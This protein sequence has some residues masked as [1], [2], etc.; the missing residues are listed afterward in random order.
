MSGNGLRPAQIF[1]V[2]TATVALL[3]IGCPLR[4]QADSKTEVAAKARAILEKHCSKCHGSTDPEE[5]LNV[6][7]RASLLDAAR[8]KLA[9]ALG[10]PDQSNLIKR[11]E[12]E[13]RPMP[14][15]KEKDPLSKDEIAT[16][17][18]W[19]EDGA[20]MVAS[21]TPAIPASA[22]A[23]LAADAREILET[24]CSR[25]H[26]YTRREKDLNVLDLNSLK[27]A[28]RRPRLK[29]A[30]VVPEKPDESA[31]LK[32]I[33]EG[34]MP[35][36]EDTPKVPKDRQDVLRAW[37]A[38]GAPAFPVVVRKPQTPLGTTTSTSKLPLPQRV[39]SVFRAKCYTCHGG[40]K[41][42]AALNILKHADLIDRDRSLVVPGNAGASKV[43][44]RVRAGSMPPAGQGLPPLTDEEK[45]D[46]EQWV[47]ADAVA[48][49][50]LLTAGATGTEY[51]LQQINADVGKLMAEP[52]ARP[53]DLKFYR[54][55]SFN[56]LLAAGITK[57]DLEAHVQALTLAINHASWQKEFEKPTPLDANADRPATVFRIDTRK[58][59][60][61]EEAFATRMP[62]RR[63][64]TLWDLVLLEY[65][66][67]ML[68]AQTS[69]PSFSRTVSDYLVH[70]DA[71]RPIVCVRGDWLT[72]A[73]TRS[74][75]Y[76]DLLRLPFNLKVLE[77]R[78]GVDSSTNVEEGL[79]RRAG[80]TVSGVSR[81]NRVVERHPPRG[82]S[83]YWKSF[84]FKSSKGLENMF[85]DPINLNASGGE[86]IWSLPN[87]L[88]AY[89]VCDS[90]GNR[91]DAA[92]TEIVTDQHASDKIV[93]NGLACMRCHHQGIRTFQDDVLPALLA[94]GGAS[95]TFSM[96][97][98]EKLYAP[99]KEMDKLLAEDAGLYQAALR[100]LFGNSDVD[101]SVLI[102]PAE[103]YLEEKVTGLTAAVE[104]GRTDLDVVRAQF[105]S[106]AAVQMGMPQ[107]AVNGAVRRDAWE[108]SF[109]QVVRTLALGDA[110][111]NVNGLSRSEYQPLD[112]P[113]EMEVT[114]NKPAPARGQGRAK[115]LNIVVENKAGRGFFA[116]GDVIEIKVHNDTGRDVVVEGYVHTHQGRKFL[117]NR[118]SVPAGGRMTLDKDTIDPTP[119]KEDLVFYASDG[120]FPEGIVL[121]SGK[122]ARDR[123]EVVADRIIHQLHEIDGTRVKMKYDPGRIVK[124]TF[125]IE[126]R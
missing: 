95:R 60:W 102:K 70:A 25:C 84:D 64:L 80:V 110:V 51:V 9:V 57:R 94:F 111:P 21:A 31:L 72:T 46:I 114:L 81:N 76:E 23:A 96:E 116:A 97:H 17:R 99:R 115:L 10:R 117:L 6:L 43:V 87:G 50:P 85:R 4:A 15:K 120:A 14:P 68:P 65:P 83:Y 103:R 13:T 7:D 11:V 38:A 66:Y 104:T 82:Y 55:V 40:P 92:P 71:V 44:R 105:R 98:V 19:I 90:K 28:N 30:A 77:Q 26:G 89:Y 62:D 20:E 36:G 93:R 49:D 52:R 1:A 41:P 122:N 119:G 18:K 107:L 42:E 22:G 100:K 125:E 74:P 109:D 54:Y 24:H 86:M 69:A 124:R 34:T 3:V 126:T 48:W 73:V 56:H 63:T 12:S 67:G 78:L 59:G 45:A 8:T 27:D 118:L 75:L 123:G 58:L 39:E 101:G 112:A 5:N 53:G 16:L 79:A 106:A 35:P 88:Q 91:I 29:A 33:R 2:L 108:D 61:H 121:T 37:I 113:F 32:R 47:N